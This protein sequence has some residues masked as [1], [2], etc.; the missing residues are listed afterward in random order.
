MKYILTNNAL[1]LNIEL[2]KLSVLDNTEMAYFET[3]THPDSGDTAMGIVDLDYEILVHP[4]CDVEEL[5]SLVTAYT[6]EQEEQLGNYIDSIAIPQTGTEPKSGFILGR[7]PFR[8][9]VE[10]FVDIHDEQY[11]IDNGWNI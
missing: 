8:N 3:I 1:A 10:G 7:F 2:Y 11:M 5:K 6:P 4:N 9:I